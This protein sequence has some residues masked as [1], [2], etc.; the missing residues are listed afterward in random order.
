MVAFNLL[1]YPGSGWV[2]GLAAVGRP[3]DPQ[4]PTN[5]AA[6]LLRHVTIV[7]RLATDFGRPDLFSFFHDVG[8]LAAL[9]ISAGL[10]LL[11][12]RLGPIRVAAWIL[13]V[14]ILLGPALWPWYLLAPLLLFAVAGTYVERALLAVLSVLVLYVTLPG[15]QPALS[16]MKGSTPAWISLGVLAFV[17]AGA[18]CLSALRRRT[19]PVLTEAQE[20]STRVTATADE[21]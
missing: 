17:G 16:L 11:L 20:G 2:H 21:R 13:T 4:T 9:V 7:H 14:V 12:P 3:R 8:Q 5:A 6:V 19:Q 15:G 18:L 10:L 1:P